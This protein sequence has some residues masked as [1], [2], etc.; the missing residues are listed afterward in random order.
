MKNDRSQPDQERRRQLDEARDLFWAEGF[1]VS[2]AVLSQQ[3]HLNRKVVYEQYGDKKELFR[4]ALAHYRRSISQP[5]LALLRGPGPGLER[6]DRFFAQFEPI[7]SDPVSRMGCLMVATAVS[8]ASHDEEI[9]AE[10][11]GFVDEVRSL[12]A[13]ALRDA[14]PPGPLEELTDYFTGALFGLMALARSPAPRP[15]VAGYLAGV[16]R[17]ITTLEGTP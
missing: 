10:V 15:T 14:A 13:A 2:I 5:Q 6:I 7:V 4:A 12:F 17:F 3:P 1:E 8:A 9:G 16:R 11:A